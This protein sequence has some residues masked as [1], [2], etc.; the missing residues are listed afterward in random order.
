MYRMFSEENQP[1]S[2]LMPVRNAAAMV[3]AAL[4]DLLLAVESQDELVVVDDGSEDGTAKVLKECRD[5]RLRVVTT[6]G[7]GLVQALN[8][9]LREATHEWIAR[10]DADDRYPHS[11]LALQRKLRKSG[12]ALVSGDYGI[13]AKGNLIGVLPTAVTHP[14]VLTS[15]VHP[16][17][18]PHPGVLINRQA[19]IAAGTYRESDFPIEDLALWLR[20]AS[21]GS[22]VGTPHNVVRWTMSSGS[23]THSLRDLQRARAA[24]LVQ[25][26]FRNARLQSVDEEMV[27]LE[28]ASYV[29]TSRAM[30]RAILLAYDLRALRS[31]GLPDARYRQVLAALRQDPLASSRALW[32]LEVERRRRSRVRRAFRRQAP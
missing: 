30:E 13:V 5:P 10:A 27:A 26:H 9:G 16:Q 3:G 18:I 25:E 24:T 12:V 14:F 11:R 19:V 4:S 29:E 17:R 22:L 28:L 15:L 23:I 21:I 8:L 2:V 32:R 20:L 31:W 6:K 7:I 1:I